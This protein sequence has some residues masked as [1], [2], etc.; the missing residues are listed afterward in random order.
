[1]NE[2]GMVMMDVVTTENLQ[3]AEPLA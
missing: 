1:M 2:G 3:T